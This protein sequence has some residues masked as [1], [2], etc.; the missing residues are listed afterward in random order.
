MFNIDFAKYL[1]YQEKEM[2]ETVDEVKEANEQLEL[3][4][5]QLKN[6]TNEGSTK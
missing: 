5:N 2:K 4:L 3:L 6:S 1:T